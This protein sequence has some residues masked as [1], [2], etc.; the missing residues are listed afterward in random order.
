MAP[1]FAKS[2]S[3]PRGPAQAPPAAMAAIIAVTTATLPSD[4][5]PDF[6]GAAVVGEVVGVT[7]GFRPAHSS[8]AVSQYSDSH[9][10]Q[11]GDSAFAQSDEQYSSAQLSSWPIHSAQGLVIFHDP[12]P[13]RGLGNPLRLVHAVGNAFDERRGGARRSE[14]GVARRKKIR[15]RTN[16]Q[17]A[18]ESCV[19]QQ[20]SETRRVRDVMFLNMH[21]RPLTATDYTSD[22]FAL[23]VLSVS[24]TMTVSAYN[25]IVAECRNVLRQLEMGTA[26]ADAPT[27]AALEQVLVVLRASDGD[28][29]ETEH[30]A[31]AE[32]DER[33]IE[34]RAT[35]AGGAEPGEGEESDEEA[36]GLPAH[37]D[38]DVAT[39]A[40]ADGDERAAP[41]ATGSAPHA[42]ASAGSSTGAT[43]PPAGANVAPSIPT[44]AAVPV[45]APT[46]ATNAA[47]VPRKTALLR[48]FVAGWFRGHFTGRYLRFGK[49]C[50]AAVAEPIAQLPFRTASASIGLG[51]SLE[52]PGWSATPDG[53]GLE[54]VRPL[55]ALPDD[56]PEQV[57]VLDEGKSH[58]S[59]TTYGA[60]VAA[61][62][63]FKEH[64]DAQVAVPIDLAT[65]EAV[66]AVPSRAHLLQILTQM[67]VW[68]VFYERYTVSSARGIIYSVLL[69]LK[70][71]V[72]AAFVF[73]VGRVLGP[74]L[75]PFA[76][77][78]EF[79]DT[80]DAPDVISKIMTALVAQ[81]PAL[82]QEE[83]AL[84]E[85]HL[86]RSVAI[87]RGVPRAAPFQYTIYP[88]HVI[89]NG[90]AWHYN[91]LK[92]GVDRVSQ[93]VV[94]LLQALEFWP[95]TFSWESKTAAHAGRRLAAGCA[96]GRRVQ[97]VSR[98]HERIR[99][100]PQ[101]PRAA[102]PHHRRPGGHGSR[103]RGHVGGDSRAGPCRNGVVAGRCASD[104]RGGDGRDT[105]HLGAARASWRDGVVARAVGGNARACARWVGG[106]SVGRRFR[107]GRD[108]GEHERVGRIAPRR[109]GGGDAAKQ[110]APP[111]RGN[112]PDGAGSPG[113]ERGRPGHASADGW[114]RGRAC[115]RTWPKLR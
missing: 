46:G 56:E 94:R 47:P 65:P 34:A 81:H 18:P 92:G 35:A 45:G 112:H 13:L 64:M 97:V 6:V 51:E 50:E 106:W 38:P 108:G 21:A 2:V 79:N 27:A 73:V 24:G 52:V 111:A 71:D 98:R 103:A 89:K 76:P 15:G 33:A 82:T 80:I 1:H 104:Q 66:R 42:G 58:L 4:A 53:V 70:A 12:V 54:L 110:G 105:Q 3:R 114:H 87:R 40:G 113:F 11:A 43:P 31:V 72:L 10:Q 7:T 44:M 60:A 90:L 36:G 75:A 22:W 85:S 28:L 25:D 49:D 88:V 39:G 26:P 14:G 48:K 77:L 115:A 20:S 19:A 67:G 55:G 63:E 84:V 74:V 16:A 17:F 109:G 59:P 68:R 23:R 57:L 78:H 62:Q 100:V 32:E 86:P 61:G 30:V 9:S 8:N 99:D 83:L 5:A 91:I 102:G 95:Q 29:S 96:R 101:Q 37:E 107:A 93:Y 41:D 69:G